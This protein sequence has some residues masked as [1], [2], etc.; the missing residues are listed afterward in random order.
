MIDRPYIRSDNATIVCR[1]HEYFSGPNLVVIVRVVALLRLQLGGLLHALRLR[2]GRLDAA[3]SEKCFLLQLLPLVLHHDDVGLLQRVVVAVADL[4]RAWL[5]IVEHPNPEEAKG[6][7]DLQRGSHQRT[8][9]T[10][11]VSKLEPK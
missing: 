3:D 5:E 7:L 2:L 4:K 11:Q 10:H 6:D 8:F 9:P 1:V